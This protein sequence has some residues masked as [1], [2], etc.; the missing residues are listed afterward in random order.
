MTSEAE[1][2]VLIL[3]R[4]SVIDCAVPD[5]ITRDGAIAI[6]GERIVAVGPREEVLAST[7]GAAVTAVDLAGQCVLP[8]LWDSHIHL[9]AVVPP[10][11]AEYAHE[12]PQHHMIRAIRKAQDNLRCGITS[13]RSLGEEFDGDLVLR[14]AI[15]AG[16]I[17]GPRIFASGD[18]AWSRRAAG[19]EEF[20]REVRRA[21]AAGVDQIKLLSSGGIP[22]RSNSIGHSLHRDEEIEAATEEAHRWGKPIAVHAMGDTTVIA[23]A[24]A[25]VD[26]IE[27]A[28]VAT[29]LGVAAMAEAGTMLCPNLAVTDAWDPKRLQVAGYPAWFVT[30]AAEARSRHRTMFEEALRLGIP[31]LAGVDDLPEGRAPVGIEMHKGEIGLIAELRLMVRY[32]MSP[33]A[34]LCTATRNAARSV[35]ADQILGTV[36]VGKLADLIVCAENP[37]DDLA[38]LSSLTSVW[39]GGSSI[40]LTLGLEEGWVGG[41]IRER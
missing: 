37:L 40:R 4:C 29:S 22:W 12:S 24:R 31:I 25:G 5:R 32:G 21:I 13:L 35:R 27:H 16:E 10:F 14:N 36:E 1:A 26:T 8:G 19:V 28:F 30:N 41:G 39:K 7:S 15:E 20:R 17:E 3:D 33:G 23:A 9:G 2:Q 34:A 38:A 18:V 6:G 11:E